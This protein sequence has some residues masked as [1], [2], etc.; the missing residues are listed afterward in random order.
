MNCYSRIHNVLL[1]QRQS[2][3][4]L[5]SIRALSLF[6]LFTVVPDLDSQSRHWQTIA[7]QLLVNL[8]SH[9]CILAVLQL[10]L[11]FSL[12]LSV[13]LEMEVGKNSMWVVLLRLFYSMTAQNS[14][15]LRPLHCSHTLQ[16]LSILFST[17][18]FYMAYQ[19][20]IP[21]IRLCRSSLCCHKY[22]SHSSSGRRGLCCHE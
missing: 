2:L 22:G 17:F 21:F 11:I 19:F 14:V 7:Y 13:T 4:L 15:C 12:K 5:H 18:T 20:S 9:P 16:Y 3:V 1:F 10:H 6:T 8:A